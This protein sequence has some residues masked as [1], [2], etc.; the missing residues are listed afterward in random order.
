MYYMYYYACDE[1]LLR[2]IISFAIN[3]VSF[4]PVTTKAFYDPIV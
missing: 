3:I 2:V 1:Y 4:A